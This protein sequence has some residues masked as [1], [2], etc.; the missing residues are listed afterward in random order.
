MDGTVIPEQPAYK[1]HR[2]AVLKISK[3]RQP[4]AKD[5]QDLSHSFRYWFQISDVDVV[6]LLDIAVLH[7]CG[8][9]YMLVAAIVKN[10]LV[11]SRA[12]ASFSIISSLPLLK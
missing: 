12:P 7:A 2:R 10:L 4:C 8:R 6:L 11:Y 3:Q 1:S 5:V 9:D